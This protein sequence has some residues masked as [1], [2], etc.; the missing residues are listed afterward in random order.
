MEAVDP[1]LAQLKMEIV[2][3]ILPIDLIDIEEPRCIIS[4]TVNADPIL[5]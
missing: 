3:P 4:N 5:T 2:D 1:N